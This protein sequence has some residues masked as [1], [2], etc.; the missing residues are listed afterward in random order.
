MPVP[1]CFPQQR[2]K[3]LLFDWDNTLVDTWLTCYEALNKTLL[4]YG[5]V[6]H[7]PEQF[8]KQP[9]L[10]LRESFP[11]IFEDKALEAE[12]FFYDQVHDTH[13]ETLR[14]LPGAEK[15]LQWALQKGVYVGVV[16]NK[17]G[18][19]LRKEVQHLGWGKYFEKI[20]GSYD[21]E[22]DKPSHIPLLAA[23]QDSSLDPGHHVWFVGDSCVDVQCAQ[24][25][26]CVPVAIGDNA[27]KPEEIV[28]FGKDCI[29][30]SHI[31]SALPV[32]EQLLEVG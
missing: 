19:L 16:S 25:A 1:S 11:S 30:L 7:T 2:P 31:L 12:Q 18:Q 26:G 22:A 5:H 6:P 4:F 27:A 10:S 20:I 13:L 28:V 21:T 3:A 23:L 15:L 8:S 14:P 9:H 29:R 24:R 17:A 32:E